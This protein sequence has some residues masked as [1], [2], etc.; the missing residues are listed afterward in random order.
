MSA[1]PQAVRPLNSTCTLTGSDCDSMGPLLFWPPRRAVPVPDAVSPPQ[2]L[3]EI[4]GKPG[5]T[6]PVPIM[7]NVGPNA[8]SGFGSNPSLISVG[9][10]DISDGAS[11]Q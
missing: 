10:S 11:G 7:T 2:L 5:A 9:R 1:P 4:A 8:V 6:Y 3:H